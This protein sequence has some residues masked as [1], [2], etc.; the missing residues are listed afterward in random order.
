MCCRWRANAET[1]ARA[2]TNCL[3]LKQVASPRS[4]MGRSEL[5]FPAIGTELGTGGS[6]HV[7][8][9]GGTWGFVV[10]GQFLAN[11]SV[12]SSCIKSSQKLRLFMQLLA[13]TGDL[14][15]VA[16]HCN[17]SKPHRFQLIIAGSS[18][19][20]RAGPPYY[21]N[22]PGVLG[23]FLA[24]LRFGVAGRPVTDCC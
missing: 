9:G 10:L 18:V 8:F 12:L 14:Q 6:R 4:R 5:G 22:W 3:I 11:F 1:N 24:V 17:W 19:Q 21:K 20:V 15:L 2:R 16:T 7:W 23:Q 13:N